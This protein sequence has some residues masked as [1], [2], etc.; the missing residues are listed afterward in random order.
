[1]PDLPCEFVAVWKGVTEDLA[2]ELTDFWARNRAIPDADRA[3]ARARQA[4]CIARGTDGSLVGVGTAVMRI[5]PRLRQPMYYYRQFF[6]PDF[7][8]QKQTVPFFNFAREVLESYNA[9]L[10]QPE[11]LGVL[12]ELE[13]AMLASRYVLAHEPTANSTF[14]GYSQK[15]L[16]LRVTYF[17]GAKLQPLSPLP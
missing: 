17:E 10:K 15:G 6:S 5:L 3:A 14:I 8:G 13:N 4:V 7:R 12:L 1:M 2:A 9:A 11:S 16:Q